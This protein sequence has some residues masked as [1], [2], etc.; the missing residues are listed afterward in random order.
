MKECPVRGDSKA[1]GAQ[2]A[3][4]WAQNCFLTLEDGYG[5]GQIETRGGGSLSK[6]QVLRSVAES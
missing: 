5:R 4:A 2:A 3:A 1:A 6:A